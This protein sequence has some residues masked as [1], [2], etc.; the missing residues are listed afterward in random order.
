VGGG[1]TNRSRVE[2]QYRLHNSMGF[3]FIANHTNPNNNHTITS[4]TM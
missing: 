1:V 3:M 2:G 4:T